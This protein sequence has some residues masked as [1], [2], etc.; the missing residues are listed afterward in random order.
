MEDIQNVKES[1]KIEGRGGVK[2]ERIT[3]VFT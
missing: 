3:H 2:F 1:N